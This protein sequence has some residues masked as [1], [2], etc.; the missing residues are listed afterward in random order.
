MNTI[1]KTA[2]KKWRGA[3][4]MNSGDVRLTLVTDMGPRALSLKLGD[5]PNLLFEDEKEELKAG[6]WKI[7]GGHRFWIG[8]ETLLTYAP[9]N[10]PCQVMETGEGLQITSPADAATGLE[11]TLI[12]SAAPQGF[13]LRHVVKNTGEFLAPAGTIWGLTCVRPRGVCAIPWRVGPDKWSVASVKFWRRWADHGSDIESPQ[14]RMTNDLFEIHPTGE[15]GKAGSLAS[16]IGQWSDDATFIKSVKMCPHAPYPDGGCNIE[17]Y[18][19]KFFIELESLSPV[20][21]L[22]PGETLE[23]EERWI[24]TRP[25]ERSLKAVQALL[26]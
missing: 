3:Y 20:R 2:Y 9:D 6:D 10:A 11:K 4:Q 25:V 7:Y 23:H 26:A 12:V 5:G 15:E 21:I 18:T 16:W 8:P 19:C 14:W 22:G 1:E 13:R 17:I 24:V